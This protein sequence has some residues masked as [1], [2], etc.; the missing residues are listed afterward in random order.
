MRFS[1]T[2]TVASAVAAPVKFSLAAPETLPGSGSPAAATTLTDRLRWTRSRRGR[3]LNPD[4]CVGVAAH[5]TVPGPSASAAP[6]AVR[7]ATRMSGSLSWR[8]TEATTCPMT[9]LVTSHHRS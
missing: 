3:D 4:G 6:P 8:R 2:S 1:V 5:V 7:S 9:R